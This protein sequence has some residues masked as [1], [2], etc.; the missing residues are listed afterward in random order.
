MIIIIIK[1]P[2]NPRD[3]RT[4]AEVD[5]SGYKGWKTLFG[6]DT[7][8]SSLTPL[9]LTLQVQSVSKS[10]QLQLQNPFRTQPFLT[11]S[12][13]T[14]QARGPLSVLTSTIARTSTFLFPS[15]M[16]RSLPQ[17]ILHTVVSQ[18]GKHFSSD[19]TVTCLL[20]VSPRKKVSSMKARSSIFGLCY[21]SRDQHNA[22]L[23][24]VGTKLILLNEL[25]KQL[26]NCIPYVSK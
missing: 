1:P 17:S 19:R 11:T 6:A 16:P 9:S 12:T 15:H 24:V 14:M 26:W 18:S 4:G 10:Y 8:M 20:S 23:Y 21:I 5:F 3:M 22:K 7:C 25:H 2:E 13:A